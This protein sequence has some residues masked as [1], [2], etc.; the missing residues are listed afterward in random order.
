V[1]NSLPHEHFTL[2]SWY[3]GWV[4]IFMSRATP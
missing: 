3:S 4:S 2:T 1:V